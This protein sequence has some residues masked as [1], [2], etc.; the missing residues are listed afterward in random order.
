MNG[1]VKRAFVTGANGFIGIHLCK[2]L[3]QENWQVTALVRSSSDLE[4]LEHPNIKIVHGSVTDVDSMKKHLQEQTDCVFHLA[5]VTSQWSKD[6]ERQSEVNIT[7]TKNMIDLA[8]EKQAKRFIHVS[9]IM[10]YG[11]HKGIIDESSASNATESRNN[12]SLSKWKGENLA[13]HAFQ[14]GMDVV[15]INPS[16]VIGPIDRKNH[17]QLFQAIIDNKLPGVPPGKGMF[18]HV[19][20]VVT[21]MVLAFEKGKS[22]EKY[23]VGGYHLSFKELASEIRRQ[24]G[25]N[26]NVRTI[27][28]WVFQL[29]LPFYTVGSW[30]SK[31]EPLLTRGKIQISCKDIQCDDHKAK[32]VFGLAYKPL[33]EMVRDTLRWIESEKIT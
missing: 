7:G 22:G 23:L 11:I 16:H 2:K 33:E 24:L 17:I 13:L 5:G 32:S 1:E 10:A 18:C 30:V 12:Y 25:K 6:F 4:Y 31:K 3:V 26:E 8:S 9:S 29:M 15:I 20:D 14:S 19:K 27:P 21:A 28:E